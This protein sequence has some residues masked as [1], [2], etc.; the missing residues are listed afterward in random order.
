MDDLDE[1]LGGLGTWIAAHCGRVDD[2]VAD[3]VFNH[4]C[5]ESIERASTGRDLLQNRSTIG[6][7][8]HRTFD[9]FELAAHA[10]DPGQKLL[11]FCLRV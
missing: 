3:V 5:D 11:L 2:M 9:R 4:L 10:S 6:L 1:L 7:H 8:L